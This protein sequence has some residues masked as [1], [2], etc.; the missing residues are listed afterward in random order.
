MSATT[1]RRKAAQVRRSIL[2]TALAKLGAKE[3]DRN[4]LDDGIDHRVNFLIDASVDGE[5]IEEARF[6]RLTIGHPQTTHRSTAPNMPQLVGVLLEKL[7]K[8]TREKLLDELPRLFLADGLPDPGPELVGQ[9]EKL[10]KQLRSKTTATSRGQVVFG[11]QTP[12]EF[13]EGA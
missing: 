2:W 6:G 10:L 4:L 12:A 13:A 1:S 9:A 8:P 3:A 5:P 7:N 11:E